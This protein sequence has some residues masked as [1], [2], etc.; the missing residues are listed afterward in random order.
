MFALVALLFGV[1]HPPAAFVDTGATRIPL[2]ITSWCWDTGCGAPLGHS[3]RRITITRGAPVRVELKL[4]PLEATVTVAGT[5]ARA[6]VR[7]R[8]LSWPAAHG[9]GISAFVKYRRGWVVYTAR[10]AVR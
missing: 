5:P 9:G 4:E 6:T 1:A 7:G 2:A 8:E 10:L 3:S